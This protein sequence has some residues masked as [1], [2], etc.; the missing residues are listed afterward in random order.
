MLRSAQYFE[1]LYMVQLGMT[2]ENEERWP[3]C[4]VGQWSRHP[5]PLLSW[6][7]RHQP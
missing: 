7:S 4:F 5:Q 6:M 1:T 3:L 2:P